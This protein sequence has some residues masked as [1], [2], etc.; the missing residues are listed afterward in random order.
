MA[1]AGSARERWPN[2]V[3]HFLYFVKAEV[4]DLPTSTRFSR[5][6]SAQTMDDGF[7]RQAEW[8]AGAREMTPT[9]DELLPMTDAERQRW[10]EAFAGY[11]DEL[12]SLMD[13]IEDSLLDE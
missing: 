11:Q 7:D 1:P 10:L 3:W 5:K 4:L 9:R 12:Q 2:P 13:A 8:L 6:G